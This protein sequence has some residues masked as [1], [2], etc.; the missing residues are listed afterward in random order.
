M[1]ENGLVSFTVVEHLDDKA[2]ARLASLLE[3]G[4][5]DGE[6]AISYRAK[7]RLRHFYRTR[8]PDEAITMM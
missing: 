8:N 5:P 4:D 7:E 1:A 6:V 2:A 3:L